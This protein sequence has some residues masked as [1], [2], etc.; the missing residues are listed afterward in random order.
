MVLSSSIAAAACGRRSAEKP[1]YILSENQLESGT[2][3]LVLTGSVQ[4]LEVRLVS[5]HLQDSA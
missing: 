5:V 2:S 1:Q 4:K 3:S